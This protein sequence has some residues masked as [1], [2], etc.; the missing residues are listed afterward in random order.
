MDRHTKDKAM[1][2]VL[3]GFALLTIAVLTIIIG[4]IV[5]KGAPAISW[6]FLT[7]NPLRSGREGGIFPAI[8]GT[9]YLAGLAVLVATP[10][11]V[12]GALYLTEFTKEGRVTK[13]IRFGADTLNGVPSIIF[14]LFG[15]SFL[16]YYLGF[17]VSILSGGLTLAFMILPTIFRTSE[18]AIRAVPRWDKEGSYALGAT[19]LQTIWKVVIPQSISGIV[20]GIILG[21]GRAAGE[22]APIIFTAAILNPIMP[23]SIMQPTMA[24]SAH[25]YTLTSEG[26]S[27][28]NAFGT[29][30]VLIV[31]ILVFNFAVS[32]IRR[33]KAIRR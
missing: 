3:W 29:A 12:G 16:V 7:E 14:G 25:L 2:G 26:I 24:L 28:E 30:L 19:K 1:K 18:E 32:F 8:V 15:F 6:E 11:G 23:D 22:T 10:I 21:L 17:G 13:L 4:F 27:M 20:T 5:I 9:I 31:M 33:R